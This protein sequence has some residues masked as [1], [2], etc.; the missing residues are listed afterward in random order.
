MLPGIT[1]RLWVLQG[2]IVLNHYLPR[3]SPYRSSSYR[4]SRRTIH[5]YN[6]RL[7]YRQ[8]HKPIDV[9]TVSPGERPF[10]DTDNMNRTRRLTPLSSR[11]SF[12]I[13]AYSPAACGAE[14][15][16]GFVPATALAR[17]SSWPIRMLMSW[18][19]PWMPFAT[20]PEEGGRRIFQAV[21]ED[22]SPDDDMQ[23]APD[24]NSGDD[25]DKAQL[26]YLK[27]GKR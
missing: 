15:P 20:S 10:Q 25:D 2:L 19:L 1:R 3:F 7:R 8:E 18:I 9:V 21:F 26:F 23:D 12:T 13:C 17:A 5:A 16:S 11:L 22:A 14:R 24:A 4:V 6:Q 27:E